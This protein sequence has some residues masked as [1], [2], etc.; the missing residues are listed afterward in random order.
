MSEA[1]EAIGCSHLWKQFGDCV[2]NRDVSL[3][4]P[5]GRVHAVIGEN[6]AGKSTLMKSLYGLE[7]PDSGQVRLRG[8]TVARPSVAEA[9]ARGVGMVH[10]H[11]MLVGTLSVA[12]NVML[13]QEVTRGPF[14]DV[15]AAARQLDALSAQYGLALDPRR[16]VSELGVGE[17]QRVEIVKVLWRGA[18]VLILDEPTAVLTPREV[19]EL[20]KVL[21]GLVAGGK[22]IVLVTH[23]LDEVLALADEVTVMRRGEVVAAVKTGETSAP[24]LAR[25]MVG[26][27]IQPTG[28]R[29]RKPVAA[30]APVRLTVEDLHAGRGCATASFQIRGGEILGVAGV[31][32]NGQTE[33][34]LALAG[35]L[36]VARGRILL[37]GKPLTH[38][39]VR[40]RQRAHLAHI[41]EDRHARGLVLSMSLSSNLLLGRED[42]YATA[43][44]LDRARLRSDT[45]ELV[46]RYDVRPPEPDRAGAALLGRQP[47]KVGGRPRAPPPTLGHPVRAADPR[48]RRGRYRAHPPGAA[49]RARPGL[50]HP[51]ALGR[52]RR[53]GSSGRSHRRSSSR[54]AG[55]RRRQRRPPRFARA[56]G[57]DDV[58]R[59]VSR[60]A[61]QLARALPA[62]LARALPALWATLIAFACASGLI[63]AAHGSPLEVYRLLL[64]GT[65]RSDYGIGQVLFKATPLIFTGLSVA[66]ALRAGLFNIGAEGQLTVGAFLTA[67]TGAALPPSTPAAIAVAAC[68]IAGF[69]GGALT[70][71]IPGLLKAT[72]GS[73]EVI[74]TI[75]LNFIVRAAM[76]GAGAHWFLKE[77]IHTQPV[78]AAAQL[79]RL[80]RWFSSLHGSA[81]SLALGLALAVALVAW[82]LL[83]RTRLGFSLRVVGASPAAAETAGIAVGR[84][85]VVAMALAGGV[86]GLTGCNFV[87]GYKHYYE[88][89]FSGGIGYMGIAVAVLGRAHPLGVVAAALLFG[90]LSQGALAVNAV[91]PKEL[92]DVMQA[93]IIFAVA[94]AAP[95]VRRAVQKALVTA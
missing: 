88:D 4:V 21:R 83:K 26:R 73:H 19:D 45:R 32:G 34:A 7:P 77:S 11:F 33:L 80:G 10:Q 15:E 41:P 91:V 56:A 84:M 37:D 8:E 81:L 49:R 16:R 78:V 30:D 9:L 2:A 25:L 66:L 62:Q 31:E 46:Q 53:A 63:W 69:L 43:L 27:D 23:K 90:T 94:A 89:G 3:S 75:M 82:W 58:G 54:T 35:V 64:D 52:A 20:F 72:R 57:L 36:G 17:A 14:L 92:I 85:T 47:T 6:G 93:V 48:R 95:E 40:A 50:R 61:S 29:A 79:P 76:V 28:E 87:L 68:V 86:A 5:A 67:L 1:I 71:A 74:N 24:E 44:G 70:G 13:G 65:W 12:E 55:R 22:T 18:E 38:A 39:S 42:E 60:V 59:R 51:A